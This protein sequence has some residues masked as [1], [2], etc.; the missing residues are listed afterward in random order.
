MN[1]NNDYVGVIVNEERGWYLVHGNK[2]LVINS[3]LVGLIEEREVENK[4]EINN[5]ILDYCNDVEKV[6][7]EM[8]DIE[9]LKVRWV[10]KGRSFRIKM[11]ENGDDVEYV[12]D[13]WVIN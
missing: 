9:G 12:D 1:M 10:K 3:E 8:E 5:K 13:V 2:E 11:T 6:G 7:F 4:E